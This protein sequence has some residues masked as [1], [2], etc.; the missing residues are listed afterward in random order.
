M[1]N[2]I[3]YL[4]FLLTLLRITLISQTHASVK[5]I[6]NE[7]YLQ[8]KGVTILNIE[9]GNF[10]YARKKFYIFEAIYENSMGLNDFDHV[11][12]AFSDGLNFIVA[13]LNVNKNIWFIANGSDVAELDINNSYYDLSNGKLTAKFFIKLDWDIKQAAWI[14]IYQYCNSTKGKQT[15]WE[16]TRNKYANIL[17]R[18]TVLNLK[19]NSTR[20]NI[21]QPLEVTGT[22]VYDGS[23]VYPPDSEIL[24]V[25]IID[26]NGNKLSSAKTRNGNFKLIF[27][28]PKEVKKEIYHIYV[29]GAGDYNDGVIER[30]CL[31]FDGKHD[32]IYIQEKEKLEFTKELTIEAWILPFKDDYRPIIS[33]NEFEGIYLR[34]NPGG[35]IYFL[36]K[37]PDGKKTIIDES[38]IKLYKLDT[39]FHLALTLN[40][41]GEINIYINSTLV[42]AYELKDGI[43]HDLGN[44]I[45]IGFNKH[46]LNQFYGEMDEIRIYKRA[47]NSS[48]ITFS[49][50]EKY[51][52]NDSDLI[53]WLN[54]DE[55]KGSHVYD[56]TG[57]GIGY[58]DF[59]NEE[60]RNPAWVIDDPLNSHKLTFISDSLRINFINPITHVNVGEEVT[61]IKAY[62]IRNYDE[63]ISDGIIVLN[64]TKFRCE[65]PCKIIYSAKYVLNDS[66][67]INEIQ[68]NDITYIIW[69]RIKII[70][71]GAT[72]NSSK[73][74]QTQIVWFKAVYEYEN[75][76]FTG[77]DGILIVN[78]QPAF[79]SKEKERWEFYDSSPIKGLKTYTVTGVLD[80]K[81]GLTRINDAM[82]AITIFWYEPF[83][84]T[85]L[86]LFLISFIILFMAIGYPV[87][88]LK[89]FKS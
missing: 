25:S 86:G 82:G 78:N 26:S 88:L 33:I 30:Y 84:A 80:D 9:K 24:E 4:L 53:M 72:T 32:F 15:G 79:W 13:F 56:L 54:L 20:G 49:Y 61:C 66:Y 76:T 73:I 5:E 41:K 57:N 81:Y 35:G 21:G 2:N 55:G 17:S 34:L 59:S 65:N 8:N 7:L 70:E 62:A 10:L 37:H 45:L 69:D 83:L 60:E 52:M 75:E 27:E 19:I 6:E 43:T 64:N 31:L 67:G 68:L 1:K 87:L 28:A 39:W 63:T 71:G 89:I 46:E 18:I 14:D 38:F 58:L 12:I 44:E 22:L 48:E 23:Q 74:K 16:I 3:L 85:P 40:Y 47:I 36:L 51:P 77:S 11:G 29:D 42:K 50:K